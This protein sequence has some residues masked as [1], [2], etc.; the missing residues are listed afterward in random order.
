[1]ACLDVK[2]VENIGNQSIVI[3]KV[4][5]REIGLINHLKFRR[6]WQL[7]IISSGEVI[8]LSKRK[9]RSRRFREIRVSAKNMQKMKKAIFR[10]LKL[11]FN[12][13]KLFSCN[14]TESAQLSPKEVTPTEKMPEVSQ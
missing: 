1:M 13:F 6:L 14:E 5:C 4:K 7:E 12:T 8:S 11:Y 10:G 9:L 3:E 2:L